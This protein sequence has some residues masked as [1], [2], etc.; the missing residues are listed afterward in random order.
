M[1]LLAVLP[2]L[3]TSRMKS[4]TSLASM[5]VSWIPSIKKAAKKAASLATWIHEGMKWSDNFRKFFRMLLIILLLIFTYTEYSMMD[6]LNMEVVSILQKRGIKSLNDQQIISLCMIPHPGTLIVCLV[7]TFSLYF[8]RWSDRLLTEVHSSI[9]LQCLVAVFI[10][11]ICAMSAL[12]NR[13]HHI[14]LAEVLYIILG[15][16]WAYP[17]RVGESQPKGRKPVPSE[18][19]DQQTEKFRQAA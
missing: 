5:I 19:E 8:D 15:A 16:S 6:T 2:F 11:M 4:R 7:L 10:L 17:L 3:F 13:T 9:K 1:V 14:I 18:T 12:Q